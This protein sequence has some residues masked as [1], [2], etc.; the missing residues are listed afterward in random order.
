MI[1]EESIASVRKLVEEDRQV[2]AEIT[3]A[4][5]RVSYGSAYTV[6]SENFNF[7]KLSAHWV[8]KASLENQQI[9]RM[10]LTKSILN[11]VES[12][13]KDFLQRIVLSDGTWIYVNDLESKI[14]SVQWLLRGSK[15]LVKCETERP[16]KKIISTIFWNSQNVIFAGYLGGQ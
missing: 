13:E 4:E 10:S 5:M 6:L 2:T 8:L 3:A 1:N 14:Q 11:R 16:A 7:S 9:Q 15:G 12:G